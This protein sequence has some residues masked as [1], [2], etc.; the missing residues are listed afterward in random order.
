M[1]KDFEEVIEHIRAGRVDVTKLITKRYTPEDPDVVFREVIS[2]N[3]S[4]KNIID[5]R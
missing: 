4:L 3:K 1:P 2:N 5:F